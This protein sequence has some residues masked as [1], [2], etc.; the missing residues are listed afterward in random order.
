M[1]QWQ[2]ERSEALVDGSDALQFVRSNI[3][4]Y[5]TDII[6]AL[7]AFALLIFVLVLIALVRGRRVR[8]RVDDLSGS[9]RKLINDEEARYT[10]E[11][12]GRTRSKDPS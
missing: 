4:R 11:I 9:V 8:K 2:I 6:L 10:R 5:Q 12:L 3:E 7:C 1:T